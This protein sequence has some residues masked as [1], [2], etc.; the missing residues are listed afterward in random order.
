MKNHLSKFADEVN[1]G[2]ILG[3]TPVPNKAD[4]FTRY[5]R[6]NL[7]DF[8]RTLPQ[9]EREPKLDGRG[10]AWGFGKRKAC[11]AIANVRAGTGRVMVNGKPLIQY[12]HQPYQRYRLLK[13]LSMTSY[14]CLLDID[15]RVKGGGSTGQAEACIPALA[16]A[17]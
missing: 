8:R 14:T 6:I 2:A 9:K 13:P 17:L 11:Q 15:I 16:R 10:R 1:A 12:F 4:E 5:D 7:F 3:V